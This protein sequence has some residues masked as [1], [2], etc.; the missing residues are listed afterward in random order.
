MQQRHCHQSLPCLDAT[1][2][3]HAA[4]GNP[5]ESN[6]GA[7]GII[8]PVATTEVETDHIAFQRY[9]VARRTM[10]EA[11]ACSTTKAH[12]QRCVG[13]VFDDALGDAVGHLFLGIAEFAGRHG[14]KDSLVGPLGGE[15][16]LSDFVWVLYRADCGDGIRGIDELGTRQFRSVLKAAL[17]RAFHISTSDW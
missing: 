6:L 4:R 3:D 10:S 11:R 8:R 2:S 1:E 12:E 15:F 7:V 17:L 9:A 14:I 13:A 16:E 5:L